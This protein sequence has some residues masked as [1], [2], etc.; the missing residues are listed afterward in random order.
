MPS[1]NEV[2]RDMK[3][4]NTK[5]VRNQAIREYH[6]AHPDVSGKEIGEAF[7][8]ISKQRISKILKGGKD[9][10]RMER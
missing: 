9:N 4:P 2:E 1:G 10:E 5:R 7:G 8:G 6:K 3:Y